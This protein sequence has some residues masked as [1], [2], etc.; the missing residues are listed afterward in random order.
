MRAQRPVRK[1]LRRVYRLVPG[2]AQLG[3]GRNA[4]DPRAGEFRPRQPR[5]EDLEIL[6]APVDRGEQLLDRLHEDR[7]RRRFENAARSEGGD[8]LRRPQFL[9]R[10][11]HEFLQPWIVVVAS[12]SRSEF[13]VFS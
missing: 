9:V 1:P 8:E 10:T 12:T 2:E 5:V 13:G 3:V 11:A 7:P 6:R 4:S